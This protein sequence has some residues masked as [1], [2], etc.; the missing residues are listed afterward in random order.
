MDNAHSY[1]RAM[2]LALVSVIIAAC[3]NI[4][5]GA[6]PTVELDKRY[7]TQSAPPVMLTPE[8]KASVQN[9][10]RSK[11]ENPDSVQFG[12][13]NATQREGGIVN[14]CGWVNGKN[15]LG[16]WERY[17][18]FYARY[19]PVNQQA[20]LVTLA[21]V[22]DPRLAKLQCRDHGVPLSEQPSSI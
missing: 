1:S 16:R 12:F 9:V 5:P 15:Y 8:Q 7:Q 20:L 10:V 11:M 3:T 19:L 21:A 2:S 22:S 6:P 17:R 18:P 14:V 13:M 4:D